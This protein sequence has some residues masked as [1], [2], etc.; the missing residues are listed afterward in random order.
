MLVTMSTFRVKGGLVLALA[1]LSIPVFA[2]VSSPGIN[3]QTSIIGRTT[4]PAHAPDHVV[5]RFRPGVTQAAMKSILSRYGL[6]LKV[7]GTGEFFV[8]ATIPQVKLNAGATPVS[9]SRRLAMDPNVVWAEIDPVLTKDYIPN[10]PRFNQI[11]GLHN[12][13]QSGGTVDADVDA[14]EAW[15]NPDAFDDIIIAVCDDGFDLSHEDLQD[16]LY[17]NPGE[18]ANNGIDDDN[19]GFIDDV[20]GW[21]FSDDDNDPNPNPWDSH[22]THVV[23]TIAA[24]F[25]N[26]IGVTGIGMNNLKY[27]PLRMYGGAN[28]FMSALANSV[29]Y[30]WQN[31][32]KVVSVSYNIDGFS[33]ALAD[34]VGRAKVA[35]MVYVNS[36]GNNGQQNPPRQALRNLH[37][38]VVFV[39]AND[40]N[41]EKANFSNWG[42]LCEISA[43]GVDVMSTLTGGGYGSNS[44]TSMS[45]PLVAGVVAMIR[46]TDADLT[47]RESLDLLLASADPVGSLAGFVPGGKRANLNNALSASLKPT[48]AISTV[49]G[50]HAGGDGSSITDEDGNHYSIESEWVAGR[51]NYAA[52]EITADADGFNASNARGIKV[53]VITGSNVNATIQYLHL[54]NFTTGRFDVLSTGRMNAGTPITQTLEIRNGASNYVNPDTGQVVIRVLGLQVFKRRGAVP[55]T[56][57]HTTDMVDVTFTA[58]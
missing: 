32:A 45:T 22:G 41:D 50:T 35:D 54:Y 47:A 33:N 56:F 4:V 18:I 34:A 11:Y 43:A 53:T 44:G 42:T 13:G 23:G 8:L 58:G 2:Q 24:T 21:D 5:V 26:G 55:V 49:M 39:V 31:G 40:R 19:N 7:E 9:E 38:N 16:N 28:A 37:D 14:V 27:M 17:T 12:T 57:T 52:A 51:G 36:A 3:G 25:D 10:D 6:S 46:S 1:A 48:L 15:D 29:D 30:A 20:N